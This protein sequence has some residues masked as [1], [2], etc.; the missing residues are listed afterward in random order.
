MISVYEALEMMAEKD[1]G[2]LLVL[3]GEKLVGIFSERDYARKIDPAGEIVPR[4]LGERD[5]DLPEWSSCARSRPSR[6][7]WH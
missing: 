6:S 2:A 3:E 7:A 5:H 1:I 4:H